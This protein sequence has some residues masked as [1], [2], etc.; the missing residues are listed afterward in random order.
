MI[1]KAVPDDIPSIS[2]IYDAIHAFTPDTKPLET[3]IYN[4]Q[5]I[6]VGTYHT[7]ADL[8][9]LP[10]GFYVVNGRLIGK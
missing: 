5:G 4:L 7:A 8:R 1:R 10:T 6:R 9:E 2:A 3:P